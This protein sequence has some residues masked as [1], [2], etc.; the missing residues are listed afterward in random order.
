MYK[1]LIFVKLKDGE[2]ERIFC[3]RLAAVSRD[4]DVRICR[5]SCRGADTSGDGRHAGIFLFDEETK[6][7]MESGKSP[8]GMIPV[9]VVYRPLCRD[10]EE[11]DETLI[12]AYEGARETA[13][14]LAILAGDASGERIRLGEEDEMPEIVSVISQRGGAG[15]SSIALA[16][17]SLIPVMYG[18]KALYINY[19]PFGRKAGED[20]VTGGVSPELNRLLY[21]MAG[22]REFSLEP[23]IEEER[24]WGLL[25]TG[26]F[27]TR[28]SSLTADFLKII[29]RKAGDEWGASYIIVDVGTRLDK[30][31]MD[32][33]KMSA[34]VVEISCEEEDFF[35]D[36]ISGR[37]EIRD[38]MYIRILNR[39]KGQWSDE[40]DGTVY[41]S[42][43]GRLT[44]ESVDTGFG[45]EAGAVVKLIEEGR[46]T[47]WK[48]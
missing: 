9:R 7:Y 10:E 33:L 34:A 3:E 19:G 20:A 39:W 15:A 18:E 48:D 26:G 4:L 2:F 28:Y 30:N 36:D 38:S 13:A 14:R 6:P 11:G 29:G 1:I 44:E 40:R 8:K 17:S 35:F 46:Q 12:Y 45:T 21:Y 22:G 16:I 24:G 41:V 37:A 43:Y 32:I 47:G 42:D 27:N 5:D 23:F 31:S 25:K